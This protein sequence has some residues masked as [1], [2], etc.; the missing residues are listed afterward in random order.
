VRLR[1][2]LGG[3]IA[4][5]NHQGCLSITPLT[6]REGETKVMAVE[7][8][9]PW[10]FAALPPTW[11]PL[12]PS[13][14]ITGTILTPDT[15]AFPAKGCAI[16]AQG[17]G[18][19][20]PRDREDPPAFFSPFS[21]PVYYQQ[22][23]APPLPSKRWRKGGE[24]QG[25]AASALPVGKEG[26]GDYDGSAELLSWERGLAVIAD[27]MGCSAPRV[28]EIEVGCPIFSALD[29]VVGLPPPSCSAT[30]G[31]PGPLCSTRDA[32]RL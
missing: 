30:S 9:L 6:G 7:G 12:Q 5:P 18:V 3:G 24:G 16:G 4:T 22:P 8:K 1:T 15:G 26:E 19:P 21:P 10:R 28:I 20:I 14:I 31:P 2:Y 11:Q 17:G 25:E 32:Y 13:M 27:G 23:V 29:D